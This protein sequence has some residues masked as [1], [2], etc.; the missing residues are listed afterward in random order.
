M[1]VVT[2]TNA[3][4]SE[5]KQKVLDAIY[6]RLE[7]N[8]KDINMQRQITL[9]NKSN[10][11]TIDAFCL[12]VIRNNFYE[13]DISANCRI[14][15]TTEIN[16]LKQDVIEDL[17]E[18]KYMESN[19]DFLDLIETY[20]EYNQ[21][22]KLMEIIISIYSYIMSNPF[23]EEWLTEKIEILNLKEE[24]I[25]NFSETVWGKIIFEYAK[26]ILDDCIAKLEEESRI[27]S[28]DLN[29]IKYTDTITDDIEKYQ[30][31][32][33]TLNNWDLTVDKIKDLN[34]L[35]WP[36]NSKL[37][38]DEQY[39]V[40]EVKEI[41]DITK[42]EF[43]K[44]KEMIVYKTE[45][46]IEDTQYMYQILVKLKNLI[47]N[48]SQEFANK[49]KERNIIDFNDIE[50]M[51]LNILLKKDSDGKRIKSKVAEEYSKKFEEVAIDEYQDSNMVQETILTS[52]SRNN[53]IFMVG[54]VKQSIYKFRQ[55][56]P[57]LFLEKYQKYSLEPKDNENR[58]IQLFKN[59]RSRKN[60]LDFTNLIF[61]NIMSKSL[62][63]IDYNEDEFL[64]IGNKDYQE[65]EKQDLKIDLNIINTQEEMI[66]DWK[67][68]DSNEDE[69]K[70]D[71]EDEKVENIVIEARFVS[72]KIQE[73]INSKFQITDKNNNTRDIKYKDIAILLR[74]PGKLAPIYEQEL[75][76]NNINV[77]SDTSSSYLQSLE[78]EQIMAVLKIIDN[79]TQDIPL[80]TVLKSIIGGF[81]DNDLIE[82]RVLDRKISF[83]EVLKI[84]IDSNNINK[85]LQ[86]KIKKFLANIELWRE[87]EKYMALDELIWKIYIDTGYLEYISLMP[88]GNL[89]VQNLKMLFERAK[90]YEK[91][92]FKGLYNFISYIDKVKLSSNDFSSA[93]VIGE[94]ENVVRI[95]SIHKSKGLEFP[96]VILSGTGKK[97]NFQDLSEK[98]ILNQK[99][100]IGFKYINKDLKIEYNS[101]IKKALEIISRKEIISEEMRILYVALTR[102]KEKLI[103]VG[104]QK[105]VNK[106]IAKKNR[107]LANKNANDE[108]NKISS[109]LIEQYNTYLDWIECAIEKERQNKNENLNE[110]INFNII[111]KQ[112]IL[113]I[114]KEG[115]SKEENINNNENIIQ[116]IDEKVK[117]IK[118]SQEVI[119]DVEK[120]LNWKYRHNL[121][122]IFAKSSV[123]QIKEL[124]N[125][126]QNK[127]EDIK[128]NIIINNENLKKPKFITDNNKEKITSAEKGTLMHLC[129]QKLNENRNYTT[130][131]IKQM[132]RS[133]VEKEIISQNEADVID[134][135]KLYSYTKSNLWNELKEAKEIHKEKPF[136]INIKASDIY[137]DKE[138][139]KEDDEDILIQGIID[140]YYKNLEGQYIL[141]DYKTDYIK[142]NT[143][144]EIRELVEKYKIQIDI[145]RNALED[146]LKQKV[147]HSYIYSIYLNK[148]IEIK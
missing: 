133:L 141:V 5:M 127:K 69:K 147:E 50:H 138:I 146:S 16:L 60:I 125:N 17:F 45:E 55:A 31:I 18:K 111:N 46:I 14:A 130:E 59:F 143:E 94:N 2:F 41:R 101:T 117:N 86:E 74:S 54:D 80:V 105:D 87:E 113:A 120:K 67:Q 1:L 93:K 134:I 66:N 97:F 131:D 128:K 57:E 37:Q 76:N 65:I 28:T 132:I 23:P 92:S 119:T 106:N 82:I 79:P 123:T 30:D 91:T 81:T 90:D 51:A 73:L 63:D 22:E 68:E 140:L 89:R 129:I 118:I 114:K 112:E 145:Y 32:K 103:I 40:S 96:V 10:I 34:N 77:Y 135:D 110:L 136:Y 104:N 4:A 88:N 33:N 126:E 100:G 13:I 49:K 122:G 42:K 85:N 53:N 98:I 36:R 47:L 27:L 148:L 52:V 72:N 6:K 24:D 26:D 102:A 83:Y 75:I 61:K 84:S 11:C 78:I 38:S 15:D 116:N 21:D 29:L 43:S 62:G 8:P 139:S 58:K 39:I 108:T 64:N 107:E 44:L 20:T 137:L 124:F 56:M 71:E 48:F 142:N 9:L 19:Q 7:Q 70:D 95:L 121:I 35:N 99:Y 144:K 25:L 12:D 115:D 109:F 3:A